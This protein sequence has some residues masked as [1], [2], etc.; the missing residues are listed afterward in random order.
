MRRP[1]G[2]LVGLAA[3]SATSSALALSQPDGTPI[4]QGASLQG[5]FTSRGETRNALNDAQIIPETFVPSCG[6]T[7]EVLQRNA[8]YSNSFGWYNVTGSAPTLADL[9]EF[10]ACTDGVGTVK[11]LNIK[12]DPG[13]AGAEIGFYQATG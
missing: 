3:L 6:L 10:L 1:L 4:P 5:L 7:F 12:N 13:Y 2:L 11:T 9:H 8:G